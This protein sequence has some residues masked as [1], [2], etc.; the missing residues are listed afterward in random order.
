MR[1]SFRHIH[2]W[3]TERRIIDPHTAELLA[4]MTGK[5]D[6]EDENEK[7]DF[8]ELMQFFGDRSAE[9]SS[10]SEDMSWPEVVGLDWTWPRQNYWLPSF[11]LNCAF[12]FGV[13]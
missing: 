4:E 5:V 11:V 10:S 3:L 13:D 2:Y 6:W 1:Y 9:R 12:C 8:S 7:N